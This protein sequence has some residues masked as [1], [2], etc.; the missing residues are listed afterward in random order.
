MV[1]LGFLDSCDAQNQTMIL[2]KRVFDPVIDSNDNDGEMRRKVED[3]LERDPANPEENFGTRLPNT[4]E[5]F[6]SGNVGLKF[7]LKILEYV[8]FV[9]QEFKHG[10][11]KKAPQDK[12]IKLIMMQGAR[13]SSSTKMLA[14]VNMPSIFFGFGKAIK[15]K[16]FLLKN[17]NYYDVQTLEE[18][19]KVSTVVTVFKDHIL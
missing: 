4:P 18:D 15:M 12:M 5:N 10:K 8:D 14:K 19:D 7:Q 17:D 9:N 3:S 13:V 11:E 16:D 2:S 1:S 6:E